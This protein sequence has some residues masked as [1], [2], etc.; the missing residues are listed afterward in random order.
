M[1]RSD[2]YSR[3]MDPIIAEL[4]AGV[5]PWVQHRTATQCSVPFFGE[6]G[7]GV[8]ASVSV[9]ALSRLVF[10][11]GRGSDNLAAYESNVI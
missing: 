9:L 7:D 10:S 5:R 3:V 2:L 6:P 8:L 1:T 4:E 11:V